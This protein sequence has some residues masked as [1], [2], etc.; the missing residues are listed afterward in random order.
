MSKPSPKLVM[1]RF[2]P[3]GGWVKPSDEAVQVEPSVQAE[4]PAAAL[5]QP[6]APAKFLAQSITELGDSIVDVFN[7]LKLEDPRLQTWE[8]VNSAIR[9]M[10]DKLTEQKL[11]EER[12]VSV[13]A[14][15]AGLRSL[16]SELV[17]SAYQNEVEVHATSKV[18]VQVAESLN[19][20]ITAALKG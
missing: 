12:L 15:I 16:A 1:M 9:R 3:R 19:K 2:D 6:D 7:S 17:D 14:E 10:S 13:K 8:Q 20:K 11:L 4:E 5:P 18:R